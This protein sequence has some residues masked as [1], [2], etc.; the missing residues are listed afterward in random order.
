MAVTFRNVNLRWKCQF[1]LTLG[2]S[3]SGVTVKRALRED[4]EVGGG[5]GGGG[6]RSMAMEEGEDSAAKP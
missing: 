2:M 6:Q 5:G 4:V 1:V 3:K